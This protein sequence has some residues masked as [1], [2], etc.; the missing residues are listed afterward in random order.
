MEKTIKHLKKQHKNKSS[1]IKKR[2]NEFE[3]TGK[4]N[5][6]E[7]FVE[8]CYCLCTPLSKAERVIQVIT[9]QNKNVLLKKGQKELENLLI[10]HVRFHKN[11]SRYIIE[12]RRA[13]KNLKRLSKNPD[14][15]RDFL[16][17][18][19][20][21]LSF[22]EASHFL[23]NIGYKGLA[24]I[25]G[26]ILNCLKEHGVLK[27]NKRPKNKKEYLEIENKIKGFAKK[28]KI[29]VDELDLLFWSNKTGKVLK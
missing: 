25:D 15:A 17:E 23:R 21:G 4:K 13:L 19:I 20:K 29:P 12:A 22:K 26:H 28:V 24:I 7:L 16:V 10:R 27:S 11:K 6:E 8:L 3:K 14:E 1:E 9:S 2:L 5:I 18:N